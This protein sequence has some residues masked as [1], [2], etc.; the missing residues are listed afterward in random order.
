MRRVSLGVIQY[1]NL[2]SIGIAIVINTI[3]N[4]QKIPYYK[5]T[6]FFI[7]IS[8]KKNMNRCIKHTAIKTM[9]CLDYV[10]QEYLFLTAFRI[11]TGQN[12]TAANIL[13]RFIEISTL[14]I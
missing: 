8:T 7:A 12:Y 14:E 13:K 3:V 10:R 1:E 5:K 6:Y 4:D 2:D 11:E 9:I